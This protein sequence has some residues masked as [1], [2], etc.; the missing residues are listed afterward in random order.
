MQPGFEPSVIFI[1]ST[2]FNSLTA[3]YTQLYWEQ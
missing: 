2:V 3:A 1:P